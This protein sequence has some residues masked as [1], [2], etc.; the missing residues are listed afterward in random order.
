MLSQLAID[1]INRQYIFQCTECFTSFTFKC[2]SPRFLICSSEKCFAAVTTDCP[3]VR[4][5]DLVG[6][7]LFRTYRT[8]PLVLNFWYVRVDK[9]K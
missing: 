3:V 5:M 4:M 1:N 7:S 9:L 8:D 6:R 2:R